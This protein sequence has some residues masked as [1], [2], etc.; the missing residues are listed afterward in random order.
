LRDD[1][2]V[3]CLEGGG[4][5]SQAA[6]LA[7]DGTLLA[8]SESSDV[9][10]N[11][12]S[13]E[14]SRA[15][16]VGAVTRVL[17]EV[18]VAGQHVTHFVSALVGPR[19]GP[20]LFG[21]LIPNAAY[22]YYTERDVVFA[23][24]GIYQPHGVAVV[25]ATGASTWGMRAD[26][27][28]VVMYGGWGS[29]LG[30]EGSAYAAGLI[31]LRT[32]ARVYEGRISTPT[33]LVEALIEHFGWDPAEFRSGMYDI[34]YR[35]PISRPEIASLAILVTRLAA[36]GDAVALEITHKVAA[37]LAALALHAARSLFRPD[38]GFDVAA[39]G[40]LLNAGDLVLG[41]LREGLAK[42]FPYAT[43]T[44]GKEEPAIA[45]GRFALHNRFE[46]TY[47]RQTGS[48]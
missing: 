42:E 26:D 15:A 6:L 45:L 12:V 24:A 46:P 21:G 3:L 20:E 38:E 32:A 27:G 25:A 33:R 43:L 37:D 29:L 13:L 10:T 40:G 16:V 35:H 39:A 41:P 44:I 19:Y 36:E 4:T 22:H 2:Y 7:V 9:N 30:D 1:D 48:E 14:A 47:D 34:A 18:D 5:R 28:R 8:L 11:F 31:A 23:R 17:A